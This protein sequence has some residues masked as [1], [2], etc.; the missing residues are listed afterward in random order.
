MTKV[1]DVEENLSSAVVDN[2]DSLQITLEDDDIIVI[3]SFLIFKPGSGE[4]GYLRS[5]CKFTLLMASHIFILPNMCTFYNVCKVLRI[6]DIVDYS[7]L[8]QAWYNLGM[9][10]YHIPYCFVHD[11]LG[12]IKLIQPMGWNFMDG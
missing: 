4:R 6:L 9:E 3:E 5:V 7:I 1:S 8:P 12:Q 10:E 2:S 11:Y